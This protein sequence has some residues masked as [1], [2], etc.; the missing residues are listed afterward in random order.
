MAFLAPLFLFGIAAVALPIWLHRLQAQ[1]SVR[2]TFSS[3][4]LLET[5]D[6]QVHVQ[7]K[8]KY[9]VLLALRIAFL[10]LLAFAFAKPYLAQPPA[11]A[12][13]NAQ[14]TRIV[15]VDTSMSMSRA[16]VFSQALQTARSIIDDADEA[17]A[18]QVVAADTTLHMVSN[19]STDKRIHK[20]A[21]ASLV[22]TELR[23]DYGEMMA[24]IS[25]LAS[26]LRAPVSLHF[27]SDFQSSGMPIRFSDLVNGQI[28]AFEPHVVG[29]GSSLNWSVEYLRETA[30]GLDV[31]IAL[32]GEIE[33]ATD[34]ALMVN[35]VGVES[36]AVT[37][38]GQQSL[39]FATPQ[40]EEGP[41]RISVSIE[42]DDDM[43]ADN[44]WFHVVENNPPVEIP[45][46]TYAPA[47][48]PIT[49]LSAALESAAGN[50]YRVQPMLAGQFDTRILSRYQ[51]LVVDDIGSVDRDLERALTDY[52]Q[53]GG[54]V[55]AF[56]GDRAAAL[57]VIPVSGHRHTSG[58]I[59]VDASQFL[60]V[61]Q[62]DTGHPALSL[63]EGWHTVNVSRSMPVEL[64][65]SD[66]VLVRLE[67][68][69]PFLLEKRFA[70]GRLLLLLGGLD[71]RWN[72]L[73]LR[74][75]FVSFMVEAARYLSGVN[76]IPTTYTA[77]ASLPL[78]LTGNNSGQVVDPEGNTV[79]SLADTTREQ[80][81]KLDK[82]GFYE[83]YT[84]QGETL[85]AVNIDPL[86]SDLEPLTED[87]LERWSEALGEARGPNGVAGN[88]MSPVDSQDG[89]GRIELWHWI[90]LILA[91]VLISESFLSNTYLTPR[92]SG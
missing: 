60:S 40:F 51:W 20:D 36:R 78:T 26:T 11:I 55:L 6:R 77:G 53:A 30:D 82:T 63:T 42:T 19:L 68:G 39:H 29:A 83:V 46:L 66:R 64:Q 44:R 14:G 15:V 90:L 13:E 3:A 7:K 12:L 47:G 74:P 21:L 31:G 2:Q 37:T 85:I 58:S 9:F 69:E 52:M 4:M 43:Q 45:I 79:L 75:V 81:I 34:V 1:S 88:V 89:M 73:P 62:V 10:L 54:N 67:N 76:K 25:R 72:D 86:E 17:V 48:L 32:G 87:V 23:L 57:E 22:A 91:L 38:K 71:N 59:N 50:E 27:I 33:S 65:D 84:P 41:N 16:G 5:A 80:Q 61:G 92:R 70:Q 8:L 35:N 18:L 49:Y 56:A 24:G 28:S